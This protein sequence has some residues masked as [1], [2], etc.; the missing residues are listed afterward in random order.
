MQ[1]R[2][3][4]L[5]ARGSPTGLLLTF[6]RVFRK[7]W[8]NF[9]GVIVSV[10]V[11]VGVAVLYKMVK[12]P[13]LRSLENQPLLQSCAL[14]VGDSHPGHILESAFLTSWGLGPPLIN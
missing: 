10:C 13:S 6:Y 2:S 8:G 14:Y 4:I 7:K 12:M 11:G 5:R 9:L 1:T 3:V